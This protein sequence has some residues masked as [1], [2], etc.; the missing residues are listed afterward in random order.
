MFVGWSV[1]IEVLAVSI[2]D[3][4]DEGS[5]QSGQAAPSFVS[6]M[7]PADLRNGDDRADLAVPQQGGNAARLW[8][9]TDGVRVS[10]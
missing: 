5:W 2:G 9:A 10:W 6:V 7:K 3:S 4:A 8:R 1:N